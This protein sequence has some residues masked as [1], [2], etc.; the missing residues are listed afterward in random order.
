MKALKKIS[1][2]IFSLVLI[3]NLGF[4]NKLFAENINENEKKL[5]YVENI[6]YDENGNLANGWYDDGKDLFFF[7][8]GKKFTGLA[9][10][11]GGSKYFLNGKYGSGIYKDVLYENGAKS[12]G[13]V[14]V[15]GIFYGEDGKPA[16]WWYKDGEAWYFFQNGKKFTG[17][18][19]DSSG[20]KYFVNGKY[21]SGIYEGILY[22]NGVKSEGRVYVDGIFYGEDLKPAN[23]W[24]DDGTSWYFFQ[25][26]KKHNGYGVDGNGKRYFVNGKYVN[27]YV[28][29]LFYENGKLANW[30]Y[31]DGTAWYFFKEGKKHNGKAVDGNGEM[32]FVNGKYANTY[33]DEIFYREGKIANWWCDDGSAW[34]FF[35]NGKKYTGYGIDLS[36]KKYFVDGKYANGEYEGILYKEGLKSEGQTYINEIYY[37]ENKLPANGW[38]DDGSAWYFFRD[39]KKFTGKAVDDNGEMQFVNG[40]YANTYIDEI[41][42]REG[43]IANW[44]CDDGSAWYF[45][46]NGKKYTGYGIDLSGKK[47]FVDGKYANGEYEGILYKEGL[48]SKGQTYIKGIYYDE[49]KLPANGWYD[50]GSTWYFF[51]DGKKLTGKAVDGNGEMQFANGKYAN[52]YIDEI[53]YREG[54]IANWWYD[55]GSAWYFFKDGKKFTGHGID[56]NGKRYFVEGKYANGIYEEKLYKEGLESNGKTYINGIYYDENKLPANG[57]YDDGYD[58]FFFRDG[59]KHTGKAVD[60]NGEMDFVNG[61]YKNNRKYYMASEEV[62]MRILNAAYNT[63]SPGRN[64]CAKWVSRVYQNA[65]LGYLGGNANDMY[66]NYT[67]TSDIGKLKIGMIVAVESSSS[68]SR[69]GRIYGHVGIYIGDGKV[70]ESVGYKRVITLDNWISTYCQHHPVGFGYPPSVEK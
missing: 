19:K 27:G 29:K 6:F 37:D 47:Y 43:K 14:Y 25:N 28:N 5:V 26:G 46:Q 51:R 69:M 3:C 70:M 49:N 4:S 44:W 48:K 7:Q 56:G 9:V 31:D 68:G 23:W 54:K 12:K 32:Q 39:G 24:Y 2:M 45:F 36:G 55:D 35:Q 60:G 53:F 57:W 8:N 38:Y 30:W 62:Q 21:G 33:I 17:I 52:C 22:K 15:D 13:R 1:L 16:D 59:K 18:A 10:D 50:D 67:F 11:K 66:R 63:S 20:Y 42:Y 41:F 64:L 65:G 34:Y 58:W 61:K 40:K